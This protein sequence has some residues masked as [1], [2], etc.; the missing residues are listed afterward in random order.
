MKASSVLIVSVVL[1]MGCG[2]SSIHGGASGVDI[3]AANKHLAAGVDVNEDDLYS[4]TPLRVAARRVH[5]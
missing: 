5:K 2:E 4:G 1:L 3:D